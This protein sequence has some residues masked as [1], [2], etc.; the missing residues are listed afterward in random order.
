MK[1]I[2]W[3]ILWWPVLLGAAQSESFE[4]YHKKFVNCG[5]EIP[6][7][8]KESI[9]KEYPKSQILSED[10]DQDGINDFVIFTSEKT[11]DK[12]DGKVVILKGKADGTYELFAKSSDIEIG[13]ASVGLKNKSIY[14]TVIHNSINESLTEIYQ[15]KYRNGGIFL[16]GEEEHSYFPVDENHFNAVRISTNFL[17]GEVIETEISDGKTT[18]TEQRKIER[19]P[20]RLEEFSR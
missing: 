2:V 14:I 17:S 12:K 13:T 19:K 6:A 1:R 9:A 15:F 10:L 18:K 3:T 20:L 16:I 4:C 7:Q 11:Q 8:L 5:V